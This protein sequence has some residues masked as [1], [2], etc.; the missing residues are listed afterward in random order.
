MIENRKD[1][2]KLGTTILF[3]GIYEGKECYGLAKEGISFMAVFD[4]DDKLL[5][6]LVEL[7]P[8]IQFTNGNMR[9]FKYKT[10]K[11]S[12]ARYIYCFYHG[13]DT[14]KARSL[15][16]RHKDR[17]FDSV[18][19]NC[20]S[21]NLYLGSAIIGYD[22]KN[23]CL[24]VTSCKNDFVEVAEPLPF[25]FDILQSG[26]ITLS[27][28]ANGRLGC[29]LRNGFFFQ[30]ADLVYLAYHGFAGT[31]ITMENY[32]DLLLRF[33]NYKSWNDLSDEHLDGD[34][35]NHLEYNVTV[36]PWSLN[37]EKNNLMS[38]IKEPYCIKIGYDKGKYKILAGKLDAETDRIYYTPFITEHFGTVVAFLRGYAKKYPDH[39]FQTD[40]E[41]TNVGLFSM[42]NFGRALVNSTDSKF[43]NLDTGEGLVQG[44]GA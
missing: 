4:H 40:E 39:V 2:V 24:T 42:L 17:D 7:S 44:I 29:R 1:I 27:W 22:K 33:I 30:F 11:I 15:Y 10:I 12:V 23:N 41:N 25:L 3:E 43:K 36:I 38:K 32:E 34:F 20:M 8:T 26:K 18:V 6:E 21:D 19:E 16:V 37:S 5:E 9:L 35:H 14:S 13:I 28:R 31:S